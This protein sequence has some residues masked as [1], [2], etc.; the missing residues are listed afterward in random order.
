MKQAGQLAL[1]ARQ[2]GHALDPVRWADEALGWQAD[3]WQAQL[4]RS[5]APQVCVCCSRQ[6]GKSTTT[7][8]LAAHVAIF[9]P[10]AL[11]L[12]TSPT[13]RQAGELLIKV[14]NVLTTPGLKIKLEQNAA[15]SLEL[16]NG[17]RVLS[18]PATPEA[19][20]GF[21]APS[22]VIEDEAAFIPDELHQALRPMLAA[23]PHGRFILLSTP[24]G[25]AGHFYEAAHSPNWERFKVTAY[26]CPRIS[27]A[28][29][30]NELRDNG[31][32][33]F[34]REFLCE[35]SDSEFSFFGSD[36]IAQAF[37]CTEEPLRVRLFT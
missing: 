17:S 19:I 28:F 4:L 30:D 35:F 32:L 2:M 12:L 9:Q 8:T 1:M 7:A 14:R 20:R 31:D 29:L 16:A 37:D 3:P 13:Q 22:L 10:G 25:R 34:A 26:E 11:V 24:A 36:L 18:L 15:I 5:A 33:Y 27:K 23:S 21:S 6:S